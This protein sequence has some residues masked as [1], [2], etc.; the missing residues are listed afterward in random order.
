MLEITIT[1]QTIA[2]AMK[3]AQFIRQDEDV[4]T[5]PRGTDSPYRIRNKTG[6][7]LYVWAASETLIESEQMAVKLQD[8]EE[9]PWRFEEREKMREVF[10][11]TLKY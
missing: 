11:L 2:Q 10:P 7:T 8:G 4:L 9:A 3:A 6:Y 1:S 5:K